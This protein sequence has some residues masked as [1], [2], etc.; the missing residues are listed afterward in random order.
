MR[1]HIGKAMMKRVIIV[2]ASSGLG[3]GLA[4]MYIK[5]GWMVGVAARNATAL[6]SLRS[7]APERV[8]MA[9][10][11]ITA[12]HASRTFREFVE[13]FGGMDLYIHCAGVLAEED[14]SDAGAVRK[15]V[16]TNSLGFAIMV[17]AAFEYFRGNGKEGHIAAI[18]SI[19]GIRGLGD[20]PA[21][22][23][24]KAFD[25]TYLEA[26]RQRAHKLGMKL[27]I[28]DIKPGWTRTPLLEGRRRYMFEMDSEDVVREIFSA[29]SRGS[30][31]AVIGL[32]WR[33]LTF[34][35]RLIPSA[36]WTRLHLPLWKDRRE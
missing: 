6:E 17:D 4:E 23:A 34:F 3:H 33:L 28:T 32:R 22:S 25:S 18:T 11:D 5:A 10:I 7:S 21:Y 12:P 1:N 36:L 2:G 27:R 14:G 8:S 15:V 35:E 9:V 30:A 24:S 29:V 31:T 26:L 19:A 16:A 13:A 20:L